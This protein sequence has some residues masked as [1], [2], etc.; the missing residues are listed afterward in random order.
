MNKKI[1]MGLSCLCV[2]NIALAQSSVQLYGVIDAGIEVN[3]SGEPGAGTQTK[4]N[5]GNQSANRW[6][7]RISED[8][9]GGL[10]AI[11][12]L[13]AG[14]NLD[15]GDTLTFGTPNTLFGR[16]AIIGL[17]GSW[18]ELVL[19]RDYS[20]AY[21]TVLQGDRFKY[22]LPGTISAATQLS[23]GRVSNGVFFTS[24]SY[25]GFY[26]RLAASTGEERTEAPRDAGR[27]WGGALEYKDD[28]LLATVSMNFRRD[29]QVA[30]PVETGLFKEGGA[31]LTYNFQPYSVNAGYFFTDPL[32]GP[33]GSVDRTRTFWLGGEVK[34]GAS[35]VYTQISNVRFKNTGGED[36]DAFTY[37]IAY[38]YALSKRSN[39]YAAFGGV[40]NDGH[41]RLRLSTGS[42]SVGGNVFGADPRALVVGMRHS[43]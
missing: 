19:G 37:G 26:A 15:A 4:M 40:F 23:N 18:G 35:S 24:A 31:S 36:G 25:S 32:S 8:L 22:G 5:T 27:F 7:F 21:W 43:F 11:A 1:L 16:R 2:T 29:R 6:G 33:V 12:N 41:S 14:F 3:R 39:L 38:S 30:S 42:Q 28:R 34:F 9:G 13:E 10:K 20:P 17:S